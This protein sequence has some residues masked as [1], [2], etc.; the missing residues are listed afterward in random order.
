MIE[1]HKERLTRIIAE[2]RQRIELALPSNE[3]VNL[4]D[5]IA[6]LEYCE[7]ILKARINQA[8]RSEKK[9]FE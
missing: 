8:K 5:D 2:K 4:I 6:A 3:R 7:G 1:K 9:M